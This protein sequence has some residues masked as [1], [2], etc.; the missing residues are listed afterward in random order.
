MT[1]RGRPSMWIGT[2]IAW[3]IFDDVFDPS[4]RWRSTCSTCSPL[5]ATTES[6]PGQSGDDLIADAELA[7]AL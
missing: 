7:A 3:R 6:V 5:T 2:L 4:S 1:I